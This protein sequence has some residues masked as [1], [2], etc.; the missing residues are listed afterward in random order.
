MDNNWLDQNWHSLLAFI[1]LVVVF[2]Y[3]FWQ[4]ER[5]RRITLQLLKHFSLYV[6]FLETFPKLGDLTFVIVA[7]MIL[8]LI[9]SITPNTQEVLKR[10]ASDLGIFKSV[11]SF[12]IGAGLICLWFCISP[13]SYVAFSGLL[14]LVMFCVLLLDSLATAVTDEKNKKKQ[15]PLCPGF[16]FII[17]AF[18][19]FFLE[20]QNSKPLPERQSSGI[21]HSFI[22]EESNNA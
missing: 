8:Y 5:K 17:C 19:Y 14:L 11:L 22:L 7:F 9:F 3:S 2:V 1:I 16:L 10:K 20:I 4:R 12:V 21:L 18:V 13:S 15:I 6:F